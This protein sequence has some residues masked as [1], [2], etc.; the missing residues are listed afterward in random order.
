MLLTDNYPD[1]DTVPTGSSQDH[2][3]EHQTPSDLR[4]ERHNIF[5]GFNCCITGNRY[6]GA[7]V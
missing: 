6:Q 1:N 2:Y 7:V 3:E 4:P 5:F